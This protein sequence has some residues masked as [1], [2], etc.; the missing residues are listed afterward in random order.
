MLEPVLLHYGCGYGGCGSDVLLDDAVLGEGAALAEDLV[1]D[2]RDHLNS[3]GPAKEGEVGLLLDA[4][5]LP[6]GNAELLEVGAGVGVV[7]VVA[8]QVAP[9]A[10]DHISYAMR[11]VVLGTFDVE[12]PEL[13]VAREGNVV[14]W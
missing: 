10:T 3:E 12:V 9:G 6:W 13:L 2:R 4:G 14:S 5:L 11:T 1:C 8:H 7:D